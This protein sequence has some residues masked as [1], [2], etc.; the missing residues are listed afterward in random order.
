M[1]NGP[2]AATRS[3]LIS[4]VD[5]IVL[6]LT[7]LLASNLGCGGLPLPNTDPERRRQ[8][9]SVRCKF[10][11]GLLAG[12]ALILYNLLQFLAGRLV[13]L[14]RFVNFLQSLGLSRSGGPFLRSFSRVRFLLLSHISDVRI[15]YYRRICHGLAKDQTILK[16]PC[17]R[18][19]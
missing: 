18:F 15:G 7:P 12:L 4:V 17:E 6:L 9:F 14:D 10:S 8:T 11:D 1:K 19:S 13:A 3:R 2:S 16:L 5:A